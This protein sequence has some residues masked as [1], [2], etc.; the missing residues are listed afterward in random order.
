MFG[1]R[2]VFLVGV[3]THF[4]DRYTEDNFMENCAGAHVFNDH[5]EVKLP[6][7]WCSPI[8]MASQPKLLSSAEWEAYFFYNADR[9]RQG[10]GSNQ[11]RAAEDIA[12]TGR[13]GHRPTPQVDD[14]RVRDHQDGRGGRPLRRCRPRK[15]LGPSLFQDAKDEGESRTFLAPRKFQTIEALDKNFRSEK[16]FKFPTSK[17]P[18]T[19]SL[20]IIQSTSFS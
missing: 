5:C 16:F 15:T 7:E 20:G 9:K 10:D 19:V 8:K 3:G 14:R 11:R 4:Y 17:F 6:I 1:S 12:G 2:K 13:L 18:E